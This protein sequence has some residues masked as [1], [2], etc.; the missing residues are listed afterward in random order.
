LQHVQ[1]RHPQRVG[2]VVEGD[3]EALPQMRPL[4]GV[5]VAQVG[6]AAQPGQQACRG[7]ARFGDRVVAAGED[8]GDLLHGHRIPGFQ[9]DDEVVAGAPRLV[10]EAHLGGQ[11]G[12]APPRG[13]AGRHR[14]RDA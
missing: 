6:V 10:D 13:G 5:A 1:S 14:D 8:R 7:V 3:V 11:R 9:C 4:P 12:I 2:A